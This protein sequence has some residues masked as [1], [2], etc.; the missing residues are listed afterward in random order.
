MPTLPRCPRQ[1]FA[2]AVVVF[3]P[4]LFLG[5]HGWRWLLPGLVIAAAALLSTVGGSAGYG[6]HHYGIAVPFIMR[7]ASEGASV[8]RK[9]DLAASPTA[10]QHR[11][12]RPRR[13]RNWRGDIVLS[14]VIVLLFNIVLVDTP[15]SP[16][17]WMGIPGR[18]LDENR[19]GIIARDQLKDRF[20][21]EQVP[22]QV[23][24]AASLYLAPRL[25]DR[26]TLYVVRYEEGQGG[27]RLL[28]V[29][30]KV[31]YVVSDAL[32]DMRQ[33]FPFGGVQSLTSAEQVEIGQMVR[34]PDFGL[35]VA[36]DGLLLFQRGA[37]AS[38]RLVQQ[39][40]A[41]SGDAVVRQ[42]IRNA[43]GFVDAQITPQG[44]RRYRATFRWTAGPEP[45]ERPLVAVSTLA[46][47]A[48]MRMVHLPTYALMPTTQWQPG[49]VIEETFD[50]ELPHELPA[51]R[52]QWQ[53]G[54][55]DLAHPESSNTDARSQVGTSLLIAEITVADE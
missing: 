11:R 8:L 14:L 12:T 40:E 5:W 38:S 20:L 41:R 10:S 51:G 13:R 4:A 48:G 52:Y 44:G 43:I 27:R 42:S 35:V 30:P 26:E 47:I 46:G 25:V 28:K 55:Y 9:R 6:S 17:F 53:V 15:L 45:G 37:P 3:G 33:P 23:P 29:L 2:N 50:V 49:Q 32:F 22:P 18:G 7:A 34:D 54:W 24:L 16:L 39:A 19:Y 31:D 36:R 1:R 21:R